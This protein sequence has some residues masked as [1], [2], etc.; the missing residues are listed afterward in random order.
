MRSLQGPSQLFLIASSLNM[1]GRVFGK[2]IRNLNDG[3]SLLNI[4][5]GALRSVADITIR[6]MELAEQSANGTFSLSQRRSINSEADALT[7]EFNKIVSS[8]RFNEINPFDRSNLGELSLQAGYGTNGILRKNVGEEFAR[9]V[10][11]GSFTVG[12]TSNTFGGQA[13]LVDMDGDG[14]LDL[15]SQDGATTG[16]VTIQNGNGDGRADIITT[17]DNSTVSVFLNQGTMT[18][19]A[20][21]TYVVE[22]S[23]TTSD[24]VFLSDINGDGRI[25]I[26]ASGSGGNARILLGNGDGTFGATATLTGNGGS[27]QGIVLSDINND[28]FL[29]VV[30]SSFSN[31]RF[32]I[33]KGNGDGSFNMANSYSTGGTIFS[34]TTGDVNNDGS[35][36]LIVANSNSTMQLFMGNTKSV[37]SAEFYNLNTA[38]GARSALDKL[39]EQLERINLEI[40]SLGSFQSRLEVAK[41]HL[42]VSRE[43]FRAAESRITDADVAEE[44]SK[45]LS[46]RIV[47]Q[48]AAAILAQASQQPDLALRL[49]Q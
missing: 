42:T 24:S 17:N 5:E 48:A 27:F 41:N 31:D 38:Q 12:F 15:V 28:G 21:T 49:L 18:F 29:D 11:N 30:S 37:V 2:A 22:G 7:R 20:R 9:T 3:I 40:G 32:H 1:D 34:L 33:L 46:T 45:L 14:K 26:V 19:S 35:I 47:Q 44:T 4:T 6:Q 8:V 39:R 13:Q 43:Q 10:G 25:D 23:N 36:D 16:L